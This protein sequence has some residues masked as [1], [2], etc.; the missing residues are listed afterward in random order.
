MIFRILGGAFVLLHGIVYAL[1]A[2]HSG[3]LYELQNGLP[4]PE[5]S[6]F[7]SP[8]LGSDATRTL[9]TVAC[10]VVAVGFVAGGI[11][12]LTQQTWWR[13]LLII[14]ALFSAGLFLLL[15]DGRMQQLDGQGAIGLLVSVAILVVALSLGRPEVEA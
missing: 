2:G 5:G 10:L 1:Y 6:W 11:A 13:P 9:G 12:I 7:F 3:R 14:V 15:W 4:W 8:I